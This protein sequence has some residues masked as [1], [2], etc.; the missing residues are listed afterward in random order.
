MAGARFCTSRP[1]RYMYHLGSN[2]GFVRLPLGPGGGGGAG[3]SAPCQPRPPPAKGESI[4]G[5][6][7]ISNDRAN[8]AAQGRSRARVIKGTFAREF[9]CAKNLANHR[10]PS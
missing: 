3:L 5:R 4:R 1:R 2:D 6:L 10:S 7:K 8:L 9:L